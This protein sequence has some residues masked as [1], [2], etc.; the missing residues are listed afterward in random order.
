MVKR[1]EP[2]ASS[3][4]SQVIREPSAEEIEAF[5]AGVD[6]GISIKLNENKVKTELKPNASRD[7][8]AIRVPFNRFEF[9]QLEELAVK[10][11]RTKLNTIRWALLKLAEQEQYKLGTKHAHE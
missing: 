4:A 9:N 10:T 3:Q 6:G 1:R 11:G 2:L 7:Y 8:K 5:A